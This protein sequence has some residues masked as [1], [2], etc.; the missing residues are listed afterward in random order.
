MSLLLKLLGEF[1]VRDGSGAALSLPTRK[2]RAL[3]GYLAFN[4]DRPQPRE[5]LMAL[6]WSDRSERQ[7]RQSL[8]QALL[9]IRKLG[10][11]DGALLDSDGEHV[12]LRG[13]A[14]E[15]DVRR[16]RSLLKDEPAEAVTLY[17]GPFLDG[18]SVPDPAFED[19]L[20]ATRSELHA[21]VCDAL[22]TAA[23]TSEDE[24][25]AIDFARRLVALDPLREDGHR[26]LMR[27]L[28]KS[29]DRA[30]ALRQYQACAD[31]LE[32]ELQVEPD[33]AT[34][35]L[36]GEIRRD[37]GTETKT[38]TVQPTGQ[39]DKPSLPDKPSIAVLPF[40]NLGD[41]PIADHLADGLT[42]DLT[43]ALAKVPELF[44]V[45]RNSAAT[46]KG[47]AV[48]V[49]EVAQSLG[50]RYVLESSVQKSGDRLRVTPQL[51]DAISGG[52]LWAERYDRPIE[53]IFALQDEIVRHVLIE[54][55]VRFT[56]G[57]GVR[58]AS[59]GTN[60]LEAWLY[61]IQAHAA[62]RQF[63]R[64]GTVRARELF[65]AAH[66]ADPDWSR[67]L[68]GVA[69]GHEHEARYG[70]SAS[71]EDSIARG[72]EYAERAIAMDPKDPF[73]YFALRDMNLLVAMK[74]SSP[75]EGLGPLVPQ[76]RT[77][78]RLGSA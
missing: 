55:Q 41:D 12:T 19:W 71:R 17:D 57:D 66:R 27:L 32:K 39:P 18:L 33:A 1:A 22:E 64:E 38:K 11:V 26:R 53:D 30:A 10:D 31:V 77:F 28:H 20:L 4:A 47:K 68:G 37:A 52:H 6:L 35:S 58:I 67:P 51:I 24:K 49:R 42:E 40:D 14:V 45:A 8:N 29:G 5:R 74:R 54:L 50:V 15:S 65:E 36:F 76:Q 2:T 21:L 43:A 61:W 62:L 60:N 44:V 73:G 23:E 48:I 63:T 56:E 70:W 69:I 59:R 7:A 16:L 9:S 78:E 34:R 46:Y 75:D 3:L 72:M 13:D 25:T